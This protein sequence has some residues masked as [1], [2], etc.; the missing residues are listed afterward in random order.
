M[1]QVIPLYTFRFESLYVTHRPNSCSKNTNSNEKKKQQTVVKSCFDLLEPSGRAIHVPQISTDLWQNS[2]GS[3]LRKFP[4]N[5]PAEIQGKWSGIF[6][7]DISLSFPV[8]SLGIFPHGNFPC[9]S[10]KIFKMQFNDIGKVH[11]MW[12]YPSDDLMSLFGEFKCL[13]VWG[14]F[15]LIS[16]TI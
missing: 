3:S 16:T 13:Q 4:H 12:K 5:S 1:Q 11:D 10:P 8:E 7:V 14:I 6:Y 2:R 15:P 9:A